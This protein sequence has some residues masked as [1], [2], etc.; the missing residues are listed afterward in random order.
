VNR[1][2][3]AKRCN[4]MGLTGY[5]VEVGTDRGVFASQFIRDWRGK[6][7][8]CV[9]PYRPYNEMPGN[10]LG[11]LIMASM[12]LNQYSARLKLVGCDSI[13][14]ARDLFPARTFDFVYIDADHDEQAVKADIAA[15]WPRVTRGG[16]F[17]GHDYCSTHDGVRRAVD[18][19]AAGAGVKMEY[20]DDSPQSWWC[21]KP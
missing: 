9:D 21:V 8:Y 10:R 7:L 19:F 15:W 17:A 4:T 16:V 14:A 3:F 6:E 12:V 11:D 13:E 2:D 5:A 1:Y 18:A 20:T